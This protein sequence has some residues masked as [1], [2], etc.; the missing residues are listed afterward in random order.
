[1]L[2]VIPGALPALPVAA[3]LAKHLPE[4]APTLHGWLQAGAARPQ[5]YDLRAQGCTP[6]ESWQLDRAGY[7]PEPGL[8]P[9]AGLGPLVA[10]AQADGNGPVWL[11]ELV[12]LALGTDQ[13]TLLDPGLMDLRAE[14]SAALL[15]TARPLF[16]GTGF[17]VE[18]LAA[19]RWRLR[20]PDG[21]RP[22]TASP[23]AVAGHR[24]NDWWRQD[25]E[26]RPWRRLLNE[27]QMAWHEHPVN[28]ARAARGLPPVN[29]LWL[30]GGGA[31]WTQARPAPARVYT[32]LD[33][34]QRA[35]DWAA[36]LDALAA[37]DAQHLRP[38]AGKHG[39]PAAPAELLLLGED[40]K[41]ALTL[42]P[43]G[44]LLGLLPAPKKN[45]SAWWSHPA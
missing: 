41:V 44:G 15:D 33:A 14:E 43:R 18:P 17:S 10:G 34:P 2:I 3:E 26:A 13:A 40:R 28:D 21:L 4:R 31:P 5:A 29:A 1:M 36:W 42:K 9:G 39:L 32:N 20:L 7:V 30:Y 25:A 11:A 38:L 45:W 16:E 37:L 35:G 8:P 19:E 24:L 27:I 22:Q 12:H 23:L 6:Y